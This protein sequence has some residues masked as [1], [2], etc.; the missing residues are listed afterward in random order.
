MH[1]SNDPPPLT[2]THFD[3]LVRDHPPTFAVSSLRNLNEATMEESI[4]SSLMESVGCEHPFYSKKNLS[5]RSQRLCD[6]R[7][8]TQSPSTKFL[9]LGLNA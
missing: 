3:G 7:E 1:T 8:R 9:K 2:A 5:M 6:Q 4:Q